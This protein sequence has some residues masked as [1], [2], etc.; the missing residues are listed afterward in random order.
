MSVTGIGRTVTDQVDV[1][2]LRQL[3]DPG[4]LTGLGRSAIL[5]LHG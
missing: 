2:G 4:E 1:P 3:N 5:E